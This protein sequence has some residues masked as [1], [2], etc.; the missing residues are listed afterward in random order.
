MPKVNFI[1]VQPKETKELSDNLLKKFVDLICIATG[2]IISS[3]PYLHKKISN[4]FD[5]FKMT[6][7]Y[8][9]E[10]FIYQIATLQAFLE[11]ITKPSKFCFS[12]NKYNT[13][14]ANTALLMVQQISMIDSVNEASYDKLQHYVF[15]NGIVMDD[16]ATI[17]SKK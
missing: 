3:D 8:D 9:D 4:I 17:V 1:F 11:S 7:S 14:G 2:R 10:E 15:S 16:T 5:N 13:D 12:Q 6:P